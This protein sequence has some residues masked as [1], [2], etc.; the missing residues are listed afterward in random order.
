[1]SVVMSAV[2][3]LDSAEVEGRVEKVVRG[4]GSGG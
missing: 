3:G 2:D 1:M 4:I